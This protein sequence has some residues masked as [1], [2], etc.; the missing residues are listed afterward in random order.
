MKSKLTI[1]AA[2]ATA[3]A[4]VQLAAMPTEKETRRAEPVVKKLLASEKAALRAGKKTH[5]EVAD[6]AMKHAD[7]T[8]SEAEKLLLMKGA[9]SL[10]VRAG[11]YDRAIGTIEKMQAAIPDMPDENVVSIIKSSLRNVSRNEGKALYALLDNIEAKRRNADGSANEAANYKFNYKLEDGGAVL[12][13]ISPKPVGTLVVP[14]EIDGYV[15]TRIESYNESSP[16][17]GCDKLTK[18]VLPAGLKFESF[19]AGEFISCKSLCSIDIAKSNKDFTSLDGVLYSKDLSTLCVYP[20][21]RD[22]IK[23]SP[24]TKKVGVCAFRGCALKTAKIPEGVE[25]IER[26]NLCECPNLELIEFPKSL[27]SLGACA[28]CGNDKLT[29]IVFYGDA[30]RA[31]V[32]HYT[33]GLTQEVFTGAPENLVVEVRRGSK[34]WLGPDTIELPERWPTDQKESRPIRYMGG[35]VMRPMFSGMFPGWQ[36]CPEAGREIGIVSNHRGQG[37]VAFV[38]PISPERPAV[39]SNTLTLSNGNPCLFLKM[40]S[41]AK[42]YDFLLSVL[43]NGK[44]VL[45]KQLIRTPDSAPWQDITVP[46]FAWRGQKVKIDVVLAANNWYCEHPF[47]KRLE[48]AEGTGQETCGLAGVKNGTETAEGYTWSYFIKNGEATVTAA[49]SPS[50]KGDITIPATLGGVKV[51]GLGEQLFYKCKEVTSATIPEGVTSIGPSAFDLCY[52]LKSV[53]IPSSVKTIGNWAFSAC[54]QLQS[55]TLPES[56]EYIGIGGFIN[57]RSLKTLNIPAKLS[58][59]GDSAF[60]YCT[61]LKQFTVDVENK[62]FTAIDGG[63]YSKDW[64]TLVSAPNVSTIARMPS[65]VT[66][67]GVSAFQ[68]RDRL[69]NLTIPASV[70]IIVGGA[71]HDCGGLTEVTMLGERPETPKDIFPNCGKLKAIHVPANAKS[72]AG[73]KEWFGIPLVF[74]AGVE[75]DGSGNEGQDVEYKFNYKLDNNGN[76]ILTGMPY[77]SPKPEGVL[78]VPSIIEGHKVTKL[79]EHLSFLNC[80]KMTKLILPAG[81]ESVGF[82]NFSKGCSSLAD[83]EIS[84]NNPNFTSFKGVLYSKDM[85]KVVAY[86]KA[87]DKIELS[88]QTKIIGRAA[89]NGCTFKEIEV[90]SGI[91]R[92]ESHAFV[93]MLNL[94]KIVFPASVN[95]IWMQLFQEDSNLRKIIFV[96]NAP[97]VHIEGIYGFFAYAPENIVIEVEKGTKGWNGKDSTDIPERWPK[98]QF[99]DR[100]SR[101][102]RFIGEANANDNGTAGIDD[103]NANAEPRASLLNR[104]RPVRESLSLRERREERQRRDAE[105]RALEE[106]RRQREAEQR[107]QEER[108]RAQGAEQRAQER[109]EQRR[110]LQQIREELR[111]AR[112]EREKAEQAAEQNRQATV[113]GYTWSYRVNNG[114]AMIVAKKDG[115]LSRVASSMPTGDVSIPATLNGVTVTSIDKDAFHSCNNLTGVTMPDSVVSIGENAFYGCSNLKST[116]LPKYLTIIS[117]GMFDWCTS[118]TDVTIPDPVTSIGDGAFFR[119]AFTDITIPNTVTNIGTFAFGW[120]TE[121]KSVNIPD[122]VTRV[123]AHSFSCCQGLASLKMPGRLPH[124][125]EFAFNGCLSLASVAIPGSVTNISTCAFQNCSSLTNVTMLGERPEALDDIFKGC[126]KLKAIHVPANAKSWAGMKEWQGIPLVFDAK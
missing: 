117:N 48:V 115:K 14:D 55:V 52:G 53:T 32:A 75:T 78:I 74:D 80:D 76:A 22:S 60:A 85:K 125:E 54:F 82:G 57:C 30:P 12:T 47:F 63:L 61:G 106:K 27:K 116:V 88:P 89:F 2:I 97:E 9:F 111:K 107:A 100:D 56:L 25:E 44:E 23:L 92:I 65:N 110:Q 98:S 43:V 64:S 51:T 69:E 94:E 96:G 103:G 18:V 101:P 1:V 40:A 13:G 108:Q 79:D 124:I 42:D 17:W 39:V 105:L 58:V 122:S 46:L 120:C 126:G 67:I 71:F 20:K 72:W 119:C 102:I 37:D 91:E 62:E 70:T 93:E 19:D 36:V 5:S 109:E 99:G 84:K 16:F 50:P 33:S 3:C 68:G 7:E 123:G 86:P 121:L 77:V 95:E 73:M 83:I 49:V 113:N 15:V 104:R 38:H 11:E 59:I 90:P 66:K 45:P 26:W 118:L 81:L 41:F 24:K 6:A 29:K 114:E 35:E 10:Y 31:D 87:R 21:T 28:A 112:E 8:A 34:G 4:A